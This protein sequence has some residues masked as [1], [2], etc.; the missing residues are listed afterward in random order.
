MSDEINKIKRHKIEGI[1]PKGPYLPC[2]HMTDRA[3]LAGYPRNIV[4]T[5]L[6]SLFY[7]QPGSLYAT[8]SVSWQLMTSWCKVPEHQQPLY[9]PD[10]PKCS[11]LNSRRFNKFVN[12]LMDYW[13]QT[14]N[15]YHTDLLTHWGRDKMDAISQTTLSD[16]FSWMKMLEFRLTFNW[17]LF[18]RV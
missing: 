11:G 12:F 1:L 9:W 8:R 10:S 17:S 16:A 7:G 15:N 2:L 3:L 13:L 14:I 4:D 18:L 6:E 5:V